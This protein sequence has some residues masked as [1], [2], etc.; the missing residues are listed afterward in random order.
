MGSVRGHWSLVEQ[1]SRDYCDPG[2][3]RFHL[4]F[5]PIGERQ[6]AAKHCCARRDARVVEVAD[7]LARAGPFDDCRALAHNRRVLDCRDPTGQAA[8]LVE[9]GLEL[10]GPIGMVLARVFGGGDRCDSNRVARALT[11]VAT[12]GHKL[13]FRVAEV[14]AKCARRNYGARDFHR[15]AGRRDCLSRYLVLIT[16]KISWT[17][18]NRADRYCDVHRSSCPSILGSVGLGSGTYAVKL[19][20]HS[21][22]SENKIYPSMCVDSYLEQRLCLRADS[23]E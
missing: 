8:F 12:I 7:A 6:A 14:I 9:L 13:I 15:A 3:G 19:Y 21:R 18:C 4:V 10:G 22:S 17:C 20:A 11:G 2:P 1:R 5:H 16:A 23:A